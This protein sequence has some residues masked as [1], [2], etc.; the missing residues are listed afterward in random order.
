MSFGKLLPKIF[1]SSGMSKAYDIRSRGQV[2]GSI[3]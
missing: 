3:L 1:I 2:C